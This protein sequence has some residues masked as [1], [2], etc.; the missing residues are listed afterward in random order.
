MSK[1]E[2]TSWGEVSEWYDDLVEGEDSYQKKVIEPNLIRNL[3]V[4]GGEKILDIACGQGYFSG[5]LAEKGADVTGTDI[6]KELIDIAKQKYSKAKFIVSPADKIPLEDQSVDVV[7]I[8]LAIQNIEN[9]KGVFEECKRVLKDQGRIF[10]VLNHPSFRI[11]DRSSWQWSENNQMYRRVDGYLGESKKEI[12]M[13][14]GSKRKNFTVS[15]H[16][17]LQY[18]SK[19]LHN[20]GFA[21]SKI[22]EWISHKESQKG[23][24]QKEENRMR[25]EIPLFM[26]IEG[27]KK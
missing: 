21:I 6:S 25:K 24:R 4:K 20:S 5:V 3:N 18:Y 1:K 11:P 2:N 15:F 27:F 16:R 13:N 10:L 19:L 23:P 26:Y 17:S 8:V 12:D 7:L 14:P 9:V 22:E